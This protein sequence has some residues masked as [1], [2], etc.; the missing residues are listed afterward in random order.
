MKLKT[1]IRGKRLIR[2]NKK[3]IKKILDLI[4]YDYRNWARVVMYDD[5]IALLKDLN[6][7]RS[8]TLEISAGPYFKEKLNFHSY[9]EAN[10]PWFDICK[11]VLENKFDL[12]IAD[13]VFEHLLY[14]HKA[15]KNVYSMLK[16]GGFF[17][18]TTPFLIKL[19]PVPNDCTRWTETGIK[20]FL[21]EAGFP[22][23]EIKTKSWGN[24]A[25]VKANFNKWKNKG[26]FH[27]IKNEPEFPVVVWALAKKIDD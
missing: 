3:K 4:R 23:D 17:L 21:N 18:I 13:Q 14:P 7:E 10:F 20:Y 6:L 25:C 24:R 15:A 12:I 19:H 9:R 11:D 16:A 5:C 22:F 8:D 26:W 27:S 2:K 1:L